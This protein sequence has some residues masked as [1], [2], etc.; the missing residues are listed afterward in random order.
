MSRDLEKLDIGFREV[1]ILDVAASRAMGSLMNQALHPF[2]TNPYRRIRQETHGFILE[3]ADH[4]PV[5]GYV[6]ASLVP[7]VKSLLGKATSTSPDQQEAA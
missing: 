7:A 1:L 2:K 6:S 4:V 5:S 3:N